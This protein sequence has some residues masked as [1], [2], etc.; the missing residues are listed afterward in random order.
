MNGMKGIRMDAFFRIGC[1]GSTVYHEF[2]KLSTGV[3]RAQT[4]FPY[5][6]SSRS[7]F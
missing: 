4:I 2:Q 7:S 3:Y 1:P 6:R 5:L